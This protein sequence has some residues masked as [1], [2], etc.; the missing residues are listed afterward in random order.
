MPKLVNFAPTLT[1]QQNGTPYSTEFNDIYYDSESGYQQS[2]Q[3]FLYGNNI[4]ERIKQADDCFVIGETGFGTGLNFLLTLQAYHKL[5][6][7]ITL[8]KNP[9]QHSNQWPKLYFISVEKY[10]LTKRDRKSVV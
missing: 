10:P 7:E 2:E 4:S 3:V 6:Q 1:F 8:N 5:Q 9:K